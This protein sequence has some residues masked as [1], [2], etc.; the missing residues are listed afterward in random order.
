MT[1]VVTTNVKHALSEAKML[2][3][4]LKEASRMAVKYR[5]HDADEGFYIV[6]DKVERF[7][8]DAIGNE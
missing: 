7:L 6:S 5:T 2:L 1:R 8:R 3:F 4:E